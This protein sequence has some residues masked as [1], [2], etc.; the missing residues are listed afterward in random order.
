MTIHLTG[1]GEVSLEVAHDAQK[2]VESIQTMVD[3]YNSI[4]TWINTRMTESQVDEDTAATIDSDDFRMRW[5][6]LHGNSL[7]RQTKSQMRSLTS[8]N[9]V[10]SFTERSSAEP[11]YGTMGFNGLRSSSTLRIR[12]A[13]GKYADLTVNTDDTLETLLEKMSAENNS[14]PTEPFYDIFYDEDGNLRQEPLVKFSI[15]DNKLSIKTTTSNSNNEIT[16]SGTAA[17]NVLNLNYT[18]RGL[19]QIGLET[20]NEDYGKSGEL[21]FDE[22]EFMAALEDN[23]DE[24]Q[25]LMLKFAGEIDTWVKSMITSSGSTSGTLTREIENI[26]NQISSIDEYLQN[27][28]DR[29]DRQEE[30]LRKKYNSTETQ[31][32]KLTQQ[33]AAISSILTQLNGSS[34][35]SSTSSS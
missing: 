28:Q 20:T 32:S 3:S 8:Q 6:L 9:F 16:L 19:Y 13:E 26:E 1:V 11:V 22:S 34:N 5:G 23:P 17:M 14:K 21:V 30:S 18:Y 12:Y 33:A 4:M 2:A 25:A 15:D 10:F 35:S 7:L 31:L 27:Y 24:V 29:L